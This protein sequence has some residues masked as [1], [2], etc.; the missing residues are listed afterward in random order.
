[1][2]TCFI[3]REFLRCEIDLQV[4]E[5]VM[6]VRLIFHEM[7]REIILTAGVTRLPQQCQN[8]FDFAA[9]SHLSTIAGHVHRFADRLQ[10]EKEI[11]NIN[12]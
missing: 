1:M 4:M 5:R 6:L 3:A 2:R 10:E 9:L 8:L 12:R 11:Y 7:K